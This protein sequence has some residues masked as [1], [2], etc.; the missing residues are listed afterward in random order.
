MTV[1]YYVLLEVTPEKVYRREDSTSGDSLSQ[2]VHRRKW[3]DVRTYLLADV[4]HID[5]DQRRAS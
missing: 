2:L 1:D 5:G 3:E 4:R